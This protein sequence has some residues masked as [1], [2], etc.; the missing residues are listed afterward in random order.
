[1]SGQCVSILAENRWP[2]TVQTRSPLVLRDI[3]TLKSA[4]DVEV[5]ITITTADDRVRQIFEPQAPA[6]QD[7]IQALEKLH[8]SGIK[9][10]AMIAPMLPGVEGLVEKLAGKVEKVL[11][12]R[13]NYFY[14]DWVYHKYKLE[15]YLKPDFFT[16][17]GEKICRAFEER[18]TACRILF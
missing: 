6:I 2:F 3:D 4:R 9:T 11:L 17:T 1:L 15:A 13:M 12:D 7:R 18:L 10:S 14:A 16:E 5:C 8:S